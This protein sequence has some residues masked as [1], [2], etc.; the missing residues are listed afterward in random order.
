MII[1]WLKESLKIFGRAKS[2][3]I[4]SLVS[5]TISILLITVSL[6]IGLLTDKIETQIKEKFIINLFLKE[7][8]PIQIVNQLSEELKTKEFVRNLIYIDKETA[9]K[10]FIKETGEDFRK[11]LDYNPI[12]ASFS[13][14]LKSEYV[15]KDSLVLIKQNLSSIN[16]VDEI[17]IEN[18]LLDKVLNI[19]K[20]INKYVFITACVLIIIS[21]YITYSTIKLVISLKHDELETMKLVGAKLSTIKMPL[22]LNELLIGFLAGILSLGL[23][24]SLLTLLEKYNPT[25]TQYHPPINFLLITLFIGPVISVIV[26][27]LVLRRI[28]LKV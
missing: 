16:E 13:I 8:I 26:S 10:N 15:N 1:F 9:A 20:S 22:V 24:K 11:I 18:E 25:L 23:I 17:A 5:L 3:S 6:Y 27:I 12:P 2:S 28:T 7:N 4:L 14:K 21:I 19:L